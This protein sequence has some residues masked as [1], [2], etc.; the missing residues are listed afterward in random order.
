MAIFSLIDAFALNNN[1]SYDFMYNNLRYKITN[2]QEKTVELVSLAPSFSDVNLIIPQNVEYEGISFSVSSLGKLSCSSS[3][4]Q[5]VKLPSTV[6]S[7]GEGA[8]L[9]CTSLSDVSLNEGIISLGKDV[10]EGCSSLE[11][12]SLPNTVRELGYECFRG[13][14]LS[15]FTCPDSLRTIGGWCFYACKSLAIVNFND[16]LN[17]IDNMAFSDCPLTEL[18][19]PVGLKTIGSNTFQHLKIK[20]VTIPK[21]VTVVQGF[22][23]CDDLEE[24]I[25]PDS[26]IEITNF[27]SCPKLSILNMKHCSYLR[28]IPSYS[29]SNA[30]LKLLEFPDTVYTWTSDYTKWGDEIP[31]TRRKTESNITLSWR[32]FYGLNFDKVVITHAVASMDRAFE[33]TTIKNLYVKQETP[34]RLTNEST[35]NAATYLTGILHVP[36]GTKDVFL[37]ANVWKNFMNIVDDIVLDYPT[38]ITIK[39]DNKAMEYGNNVPPLTYTISS[40]CD[41]TPYLSCSATSESV[42]GEYE[43]K[44]N[45]GT[46]NYSRLELVNGTLTI[47]KAPLKITAKDYTIT[48][49]DALPQAFELTYEGFKN[50]D[51]QFTLTQS[52]VAKCSATADSEPGVY[53]ITVSG[54][55]SDRYDI[56]YVSGQLTILKN[57]ENLANVAVNGIYYELLAE[58]REA[59]VTKS[60]EPLWVS[61]NDYTGSIIIP[62]SIDYGGQSYSVNSIGEYAFYGCKGLTSVTIPNSVTNIGSCAF[63]GCSNLSSVVIPNSVTSIGV[64]AFRSCTGLSSVE[65]PNSI[66]KLEYE[67]FRGSGLTSIE[68]PDGVTVIGSRPFMDCTSLSSIS[69]PQSITS[70]G[71]WA[72]RGCLSL[73]DFYCYAEKVAMVYSNAFDGTPIGNATLHVPASTVELYKVRLVWSGFMEVVALARDTYTLKYI[74]D[75]NEYKTYELKEGEEITP[76][77]EPTKEGYIF[78]GWSEIPAT[79]PSED[80]TVTGYFVKLF[81]VGDLTS[82]LNFIMNRAGSEYNQSYDL[83]RDGELN[84]G[85]VILMV[86]Q[87]HENQANAPARARAAGQQAVLD[88]LSKYTAAQFVVKVKIGA[89]VASMRLL[90]KN[91]DSHR[92]SYEPLGDGSYSVVLYSTSNQCFAA[93]EKELVEVLFADGSKGSEVAISNVLLATPESECM[94]M[95]SLPASTVTG[96]Y[97]PSIKRSSE[98]YRINGLRVSG[99]DL[100]KGIYIINGKK[101]VVK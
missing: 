33:E 78:S 31:G 3:S 67:V 58:T 44:V 36:V 21:N 85:D 96:I 53:E 37:A 41:G 98:T 75:D 87:I 93:D 55:E 7:I 77:A 63:E 9:K 27:A 39:A 100:P 56:S 54:A 35:F 12:I 79:M 101:T 65:I 51:G 6:N 59:V 82:L 25:L 24:V 80:V 29:F 2:Y 19:L 48:K 15:S 91:K 57:E 92:L 61:S 4:I 14:A 60:S 1:S 8:F 16:S 47:T 30:G 62:S 73:S 81:N 45:K 18:N 32:S 38:A 89:K 43:I 86:K 5:S 17:V 83:N 71:E 76:E 70:I 49:G 10:F 94:W 99:N 22:Q 28:S 13:T 68:I 26:V 23:G 66:T 90:G 97:C 64:G 34:I 74:V 88:D 50:Y 46:V 40:V 20:T 52:A 72:F 95:S 42:P 69:I 84:I 11:K